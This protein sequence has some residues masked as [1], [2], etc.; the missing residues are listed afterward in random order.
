MNGLI[1]VDKP[2]GI[3]SFAAAGIIKRALATKRV[4]HTGTLDPMATGVLPMLV[5][6]A[7]RLASFISDADK[8]Y[9]ATVL[10]GTETDTLDITGT[11]L[12][13]S[14]VSVNKEQLTK[15]LGEF[16]GEIEQTPPMYSAI[17]VN[18]Q[19]LYDIARSGETVERQSRSVKINSIELLSFEKNEF[20]IEV[21]CSK[22]T[23]IRSLADDIGKRL[24]CGATLKA[25]RR[26]CTAGFTID[27]CTDAD[28]I[29]LDPQKYLLSAH[30]AVPQFANVYVSSAQAKRF[31][32]GGFLALDRIKL[33]C[34]SE[35]I[36]KVFFEDEFLGLGEVD[37]QNNALKVKCIITERV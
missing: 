15:V 4:G 22:G 18:G 36:Y 20:V 13:S 1:L 31:V 9:T 14:E 12:K 6:R 33:P 29:K 24:G 11:V 21:S 32:S 16:V 25:L 28:I 8:A 19:R 10:L 17:R 7:T 27:M 26:T 30:L 2:Q 35:Q 34:S 37:S 3:T 5:G 23:Y